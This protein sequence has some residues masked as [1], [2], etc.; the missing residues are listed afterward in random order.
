MRLT[1]FVEDVR[2][3]VA[4]AAVAV[5]PIRQAGGARLK[6]LEAMAL[7]T[8]AVATT[9]GAEGLDV[10]AG[11]HLLRADDP[12]RFA[13]AVLRLLADAAQ[14][15]RLAAAARRLVEERYDWETIGRRFV[16]L[17]EETVARRRDEKV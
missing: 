1:G 2:I 16:G 9:K 6:I 11:Q 8:P 4:E 5:A 10:V 15:A 14:R 12:Q 7:G 3:P 13:D 17:V